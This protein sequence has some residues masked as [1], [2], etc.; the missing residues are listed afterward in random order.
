M[1]KALA[2]QITGLSWTARISLVVICT[3]LTSVFMYEGWY[4][5]RFTEAATVTYGVTVPSTA[6]VGI[7]GS[8]TL[9]ATGTITTAPTA[10]G[11]MSTTYTTTATDYR[12][13]TGM[14]SGT[15]VV[16]MKLYTPAYA[17]AT[18]ISAPSGSFGIRGY[19]A[20]DTWT[21]HLYAH[22]PAGVAGNKTLIATS[23][24]TTSGTG[25]T[26]TVTPT[27]TMATNPV[28][29]AGYRLL[30]EIGYTPRRD[31]LHPTGL[32]RRRRRRRL[33]PAHRD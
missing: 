5:P 21:F 16:L 13:T 11:L 23:N 15:A 19:N 3:L 10:R 29:P 32:R 28:I 25:A 1:G 4:K 26:I 18:Q 9:S 12:P 27:Y 31:Y 33:E 14:T 8:S 22:N 6:T 24:T 2:K 20:T 17:S 7:D 30:L